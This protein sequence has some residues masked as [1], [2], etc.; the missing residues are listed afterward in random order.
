MSSGSLVSIN[1]DEGNNVDEVRP[2]DTITQETIASTFSYDPSLFD[3]PLPKI[4]DD[5]DLAAFIAKYQHTFLENVIVNLG[6]EE[7]YGVPC[8]YFIKFYPVGFSRCQ[9]NGERLLLHLP[10]Q[11]YFDSESTSSEVELSRAFAVKDRDWSY[12]L[13]LS[14]NSIEVPI[15][16]VLEPGLHGIPVG[17]PTKQREYSLVYSSDKDESPRVLVNI[18]IFNADVSKKRALHGS[19]DP[20]GK[21]TMTKKVPQ[22]GAAPRPPTRVVFR[23]PKV[24]PSFLLPYGSAF[25]LAG[26]GSPSLEYQ[27]CHDFMKAMV[28][29][30]KW[31]F[32]SEGYVRLACRQ[33][34]CLLD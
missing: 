10:P 2:V 8:S 16:D 22:V 26:I 14:R 23:E 30:S 3:P 9:M 11:H 1:D 5:G 13:D 4:K 31:V 12:F 33:L 24:N 21:R 34:W 27:V 7:S 25:L 19:N 32:H 29:L 18:R 20:K 6:G 15:I 28:G 17:I